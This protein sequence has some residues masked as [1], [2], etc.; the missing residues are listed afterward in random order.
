M[1]SMVIVSVFVT[2]LTMM[3]VET[4]DRKMSYMSILKTTKVEASTKL[5]RSN[6]GAGAGWEISDI[7]CAMLAGRLSPA[8]AFVT[9]S[10]IGL[11]DGRRALRH[12]GA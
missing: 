4:V 7:A 6:T 1:N 11:G 10:T 12:R 5:R 9:R 8:A 3:D 2:V